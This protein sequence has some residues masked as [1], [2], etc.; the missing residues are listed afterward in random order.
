MVSRNTFD[1]MII[2]PIINQMFEIKQF[3]K[4]IPFA[5]ISNTFTMS[6][7]N[8]DYPPYTFPI[9]VGKENIG[10]MINNFKHK[11]QTLLKKPYAL[12][13]IAQGIGHDNYCFYSYLEMICKKYSKKHTTFQVVVPG[14]IGEDLMYYPPFNQK[15]KK[16]VKPYYS[17]VILQT[18]DDPNIILVDSPVEHKDTIRSTTRSRVRSRRT[19][20]RARSR[21]RARTH[22]S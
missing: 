14:W 15:V 9:G 17:K 19:R 20:S 11:K 18:K 2:V 12:V 4:L 6:E 3:R 5:K 1:I 13:Y 8:G 10:I 7:Y 21:R 22:R 16:I